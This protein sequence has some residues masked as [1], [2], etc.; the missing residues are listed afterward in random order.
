MQLLG[1][2]L[3][4]LELRY[5]VF[6]LHKYL[7]RRKCV[8]VDVENVKSMKITF[9]VFVSS[10]ISSTSKHKIE[11]RILGLCIRNISTNGSIHSFLL[12]PNDLTNL[13]SSHIP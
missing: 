4:L 1:I 2:N 9:Y 12:I 3:N 10:P 6:Q 8:F 13:L 7:L 11:Y 5:F